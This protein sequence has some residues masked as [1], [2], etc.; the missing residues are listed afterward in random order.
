MERHQ[1]IAA[2]EQFKKVK[3]KSISQKDFQ[4]VIVCI[5]ELKYLKK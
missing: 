2:N 3:G 4:I 5:M 1:K